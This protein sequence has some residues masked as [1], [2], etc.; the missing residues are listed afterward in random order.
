MMIY[1][2]A[3]FPFY[4]IVCQCKGFEL[5]EIFIVIIS[6]TLLGLYR[7][8]SYTNLYCPVNIFSL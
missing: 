3:K 5:G 2:N 4:I 6:F 7:K 1:T 8:T